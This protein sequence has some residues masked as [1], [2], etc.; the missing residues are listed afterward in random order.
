MYCHVQEMSPGNNN[1]IFWKVYTRH[2]LVLTFQNI[3]VHIHP[4]KY[5]NKAPTA[6]FKS[7][8]LSNSKKKITN[9]YMCT[10]LLYLITLASRLIFL[11]F[12]AS[13]CAFRWILSS[14]AAARFR[15]SLSSCILIWFTYKQGNQN[16]INAWTFNVRTKGLFY[17]QC[18]SSTSEFS[19]P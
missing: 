18:Q 10:L 13:T 3:H 19:L 7:K 6:V 16:L 2:C 15:D 1:S 17:T 5:K 4:F 14:V 8:S 12:N 9:R 11:E